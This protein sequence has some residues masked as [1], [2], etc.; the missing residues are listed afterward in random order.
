[1]KEEKSISD[2]LSERGRSA[3]VSPGSV[4]ENNNGMKSVKGGL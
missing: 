4:V 3:R 2:Y 1:M